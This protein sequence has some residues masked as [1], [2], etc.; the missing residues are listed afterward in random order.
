M[1]VGLTTK[2]INILK[3]SSNLNLYYNMI[4][5]VTGLWL[6]IT[7]FLLSANRNWQSKLVFKLIPFILGVLCIY[8][9]AKN[10]NLI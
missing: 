2:L 7:S 6:L 10:F 4:I 5:L 3:R 8:V 9:A 1:E